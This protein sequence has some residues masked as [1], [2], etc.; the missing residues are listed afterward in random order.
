MGIDA[1]TSN[2]PD[3]RKVTDNFNVEV[4]QEFRV[5]YTRALENLGGA[6]CTRTENYIF[7]RSDLSYSVRKCV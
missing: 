3:A 2:L 5:T 1:H 7:P 4:L 6:K